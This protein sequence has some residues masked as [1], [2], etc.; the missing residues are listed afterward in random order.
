MV[1]KTGVALSILSS[2]TSVT[3]MA[4]GGNQEK[5]ALWLGS[6]YHQTV[7]EDQ[8]EASEPKTQ[9]NQTIH[10]QKFKLFGND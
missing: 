2:P 4:L 9:A 10:K 1:A 3:K 6:L 7:M 5:K 8:G